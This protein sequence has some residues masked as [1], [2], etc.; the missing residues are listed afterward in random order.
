MGAMVRRLGLQE[1]QRPPKR[2]RFVAGDPLRAFGALA[3]LLAHSAYFAIAIIGPGISQGFGAYHAGPLGEIVYSVCELAVPMFFAM[4]AY[5]IGRPYVVAIVFGDKRPSTRTYARHRFLRIVPVF[6]AGIVVAL[7][8]CGRF[9]AS[10]ADL[11]AVFGFAQTYHNSLFASLA[12][13]Q[14]WTLDAEIAFYV[15]V[16]LLAWLAFQLGRRAS[17]SA[18]LIGIVVGLG[19]MFLGSVWMR[20]QVDPLSG[21]W[22]ASPPA[23]I[24]SFIPGLLF[25]ALEIPLRP[26]IERGGG[27]PRLLWRLLA[28]GAVVFAAA[29][30][31]YG[32]HSGTPTLL[33]DLAGKR[34]VFELAATACLVSWLLIRQW[35]GGGTPRLLD[36]RWAHWLGARSLSFYI[37]HQAVLLKLNPWVVK[38][39]SVWAGFAIFFLV[40][41]PITLAASALLHWLVEGRFMVGGSRDRRRRA[42]AAVAASAVVAPA[43]AAM[44]PVA[45]EQGSAA[46]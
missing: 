42:A 32:P 25:A 34:V 15:A 3:V 5:L 21:A 37:L 38:Q 44:A 45:A 26:W 36:Q 1:L 14:A 6:W 8:V 2:D 9:G 40:S 18:R 7:L 27:A 28:V 41:L 35:G 29:Y 46:S 22:L 43:A 24:A 12:I 11:L 19:A 4:S 16:P 17:P 33:Y 13:G 23:M 39:D 30:T 20:G 31:Y 10:S